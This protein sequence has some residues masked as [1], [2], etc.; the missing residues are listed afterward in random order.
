MAFSERGVDK[1]PAVL[2]RMQ[3]MSRLDSTRRN[4]LV[5]SLEA[6]L[7]KTPDRPI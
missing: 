4:Q 3:N 1:L 6:A 5:G 7:S 2:W